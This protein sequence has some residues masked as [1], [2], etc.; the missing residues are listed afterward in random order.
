MGERR[1]SLGGGGK[2]FGFV[3]GS[4]FWGGAFSMDCWPRE[5]RAE[6]RETVISP[7][8]VTYLL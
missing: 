6:K 1:G 4:C 5:R 7:S 2:E 8:S 3:G